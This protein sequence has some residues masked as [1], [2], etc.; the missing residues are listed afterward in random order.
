MIDFPFTGLGI[1]FGLASLTF[2]IHI[3]GSSDRGAW[4]IDIPQSN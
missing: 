3:P 1:W 2:S 4:S